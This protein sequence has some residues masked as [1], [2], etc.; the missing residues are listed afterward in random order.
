MDLIRILKRRAACVVSLLSKEMKP[1]NDPIKW[2][3]ED[4]KVEGSKL[5]H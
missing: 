4:N 1:L 2:C 5:E 3:Q